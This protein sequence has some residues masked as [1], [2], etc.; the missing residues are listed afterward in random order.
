[1]SQARLAGL[2]V[3]LNAH[4]TYLR[5]NLPHLDA[6][7]LR[8]EL[9]LAAAMLDCERQAIGE[10]LIAQR[11]QEARARIQ[12]RDI[13][14]VDAAEG[15]ALWAESYDEDPNPVLVME[16]PVV[17]RLLGDVRGRT[18][19]DVGCGTGRWAL[20]LVAAGATVTA[21]DPCAPMLDRAREKGQA[22]GL[23]VR[24]I[25]AGFGSLP[26]PAAFDVVLCSLV[27]SHLPSVYEPVG[28][29]ARCL[30]PGGLLVISDFHYLCHAIGWRTGLRA[31]GRRYQIENHPHD[32][33][34]YV[35][36]LRGAKMEILTIEDVLFDDSLTD[37]GLDGVVNAWKGFP[38]CM[39]IA[40]RKT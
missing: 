30:V 13:I 31:G 26:T 29:M 39:V 37:H 9:A 16:T 7:H 17:E 35:R 1:M 11:Q 18:V 6:G 27:L 4:L 5:R 25:E 22:L 34:E 28:E 21:L 10:E 3:A 33:G 19:L 8:R 12:E 24:W 36:A 14:E 32:Y 2:T 15:Y 38:L 40:A 23:Q 20:R